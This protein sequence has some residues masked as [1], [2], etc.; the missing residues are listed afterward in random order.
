MNLIPI[1]QQCFQAFQQSRRGV[2]YTIT[3]SMPI[4]YFGDL[5]T[6]YLSKIRIITVGLNPS[7]KE[8]PYENPYLRFPRNNYQQLINNEDYNF[9]G[10]F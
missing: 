7:S 4:A 5:Y 3:E 6:Y 2:S 1:Y 9:S 8:F 10:H